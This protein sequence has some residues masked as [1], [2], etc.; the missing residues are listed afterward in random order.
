MSLPLCCVLQHSHDLFRTILHLLEYSRTLCEGAGCLGLAAMLFGKV[1]VCHDAF[2]AI[3]RTNRLNRSSR[4]RRCAW[5][6]AA[7]TST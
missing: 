5:C 2:L 6:S 1:K 4:R 7:A 3:T